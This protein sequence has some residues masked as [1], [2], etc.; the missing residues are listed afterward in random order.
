MNL[1]LLYFEAMR[2]VEACRMVDWSW[3]PKDRGPARRGC[4]DLEPG[5]WDC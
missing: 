4:A 3:Q 2:M 1:T 5:R